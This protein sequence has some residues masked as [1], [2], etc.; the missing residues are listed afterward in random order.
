M[1]LRRKLILSHDF[2]WKLSDH[3]VLNNKK[4]GGLGLPGPTTVPGGMA[5][6]DST[7]P[8]MLMYFI[9][10]LILHGF[11]VDV[12]S[13]TDVLT[14]GNEFYAKNCTDIGWGFDFKVHRMTLT[15]S[16]KV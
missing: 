5:V 11:F 3:A 14:C 1:Q 16:S 12:T 2:L 6:S 9:L 13:F 15:H 7:R 10:E 4:S 8:E